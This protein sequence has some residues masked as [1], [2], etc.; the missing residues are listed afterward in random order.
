MRTLLAATAVSLLAV[1]CGDGGS[2]KPTATRSVSMTPSGGT[3]AVTIQAFAFRPNALEIPAGTTVQWSNG[4]STL[5]TV[6][7]GIRIYDDKGLV[8][9]VRPSG[10]FDLELRRQGSAASFTFPTPGRFTYFCTIHPGMDGS[11]VVT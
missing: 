1:A 11:V 10:Q 7:A 6:R 4:D 5:H 2:A 8:E 3:V 9:T